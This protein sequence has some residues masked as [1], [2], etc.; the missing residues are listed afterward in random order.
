MYIFAQHLNPAKLKGEAIKT[1]K[2]RKTGCSHP[3]LNKHQYIYIYM[4][5][6]ISL[7]SNFSHRISTFCQYILSLNCFAITFGVCLGETSSVVPK[8]KHAHCFFRGILYWII[9]NIVY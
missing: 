6:Y 2:Q 3:F 1:H 7:T 4:Y 5:I 9:R 8:E